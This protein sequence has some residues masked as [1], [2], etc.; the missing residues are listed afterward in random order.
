[1]AREIPKAYEPQQIE[2]KW[3][4]F[5]V[6]EALFRADAN[7]PPPVFSIV[8]PP[9]N[10]TGSLHIGHMLDHTEIDIMTRWHRMRG[11]NTLYLPGTD[12]AG[13]STQRVVVKKLADARRS[14][15]ASWDAKS[16]RKEFGNGRRKAAGRL[17]RRCDRSAKAATGR[18]KNS[19]C[20]RNC[21]ESVR[22]V[23]VRLYEEGLIYRA[24]LFDQLVPRL[25]DG[26]ER[27]GS[28]ARRTAWDTCGT[29]NIRWRASATE[30]RC[31]GHD[32]AGDDA[33]RYGGGGSSR[34]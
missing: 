12:H 19:R 32:A 25:L 34:R 10:V 28:G 20:R 3:A 8:I 11:Y 17:P 6:A 15:T 2:S 31:G 18:A 14:I 30:F 1:M 24:T 4:E 27:S 21:R 5:W 26:A 7:A 29:S 23:F 16:L 22:E 9:P 13:I 33:G